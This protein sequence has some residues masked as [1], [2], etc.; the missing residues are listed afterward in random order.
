MSRK[1]TR[2]QRENEF[3]WQ[4]RNRREPMFLPISKEQECTGTGWAIPIGSG[5]GLS[6][7]GGFVKAAMMLPLL[8]PVWLRKFGRSRKEKL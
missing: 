6:E 5:G 2:I 8:L 7:M 1:A 4:Q 3:G